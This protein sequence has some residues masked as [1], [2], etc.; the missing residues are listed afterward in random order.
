MR[1]SELRPGNAVILDGRLYVVVK[2]E[3]TKPGKGPAYAALKLK[4]LETGAHIDRRLGSTDDVEAAT[5]D[6]RTM[7]YLYTDASGHVFMDAE[8][9]D[10]VTL[11]DE[12][13]GD[14]MLYLTPN[15]QATILFH[16][17]RAVQVELPAAVEL[18]VTDTPPGIKGATATNQLKE[19]TLETGLKTRVP[20]F[21]T[22][23]EKIRVSTATG[24]YLSRASGD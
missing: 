24:E 7:E 22:T 5:L 6:R 13:M 19:A 18:T 1:A 12:F 2:N 23:G 3:H 17:G 4:D 21:I 14:A 8:T 10:Q 9:Y 15:T 11:A 20:P 16:D